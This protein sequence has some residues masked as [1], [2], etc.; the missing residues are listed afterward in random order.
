MLKTVASF[1]ES[2]KAYIA[3]GRLEAEGIPVVIV[4]EHLVQVNWMYS[5]AIG[6]VKLQVPEE[7]LEQA[8]EILSM[9]YEQELAA[10]EEAGI[11][12][13]SEEVCPQCGSSSTSVQRYSIWSLV[14]SLIFG[15]PF[16]FRKRGRVC[17]RCGSTWKTKRQLF[18]QET[19]KPKVKP[20]NILACGHCGEEYNANDYRQD[21]PEWFCKGCGKPLPKK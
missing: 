13:N 9:D 18:R 20:S 4:D 5:Q 15:M 14:P 21:A 10:I 6:G 1:R 3:R 19:T 8:R 16:F 11:E 2:Y 17:H 12:P 7:M